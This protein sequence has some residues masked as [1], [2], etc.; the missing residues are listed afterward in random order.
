MA[1]KF[2]YPNLSAKLVHISCNFSN[3]SL[4]A[5][6]N[7]SSKFQTVQK[8]FASS[9]VLPPLLPPPCLHFCTP[10][11]ST[12]MGEPFENGG[13][14]SQLPNSRRSPLQNHF[15]P[16]SSRPVGRISPSLP[17]PPTPFVSLASPAPTSRSNS[18]P[19]AAYSFRASPSP[20]RR[21]RQI[22]VLRPVPLLVGT[23]H[24]QPSSRPPNRQQP[25]R[26]SPSA[27]RPS[28]TRGRAD[29]ISHHLARVEISQ[30]AVRAADWDSRIGTTSSRL[31][32]LPFGPPPP[33]IHHFLPLPLFSIS[34]TNLPPSPTGIPL[35]AAL[36]STLGRNWLIR[37]ADL[38]AELVEVWSDENVLQSDS[39]EQLYGYLTTESAAT[40]LMMPRTTVA[41]FWR[42]RGHVLRHPEFPCLAV[43]RGVRGRGRIGRQNAR[44][45]RPTWRE[46]SPHRDYIPIE[47]V[48]TTHMH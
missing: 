8:A 24:R 29:G 26:A 11:L 43:E 41:A 3:S 18:P 2:N 14:E 7:P 21:E 25:R 15:T 5:R 20:P 4:C 30:P 10:P 33:S 42:G 12:K 37:R 31:A 46:H 27:S 34:V 9:L 22:P 40:L 45:G 35:H 13:F 38:A 48:R 32:D 17:R 19:S 6:Q 1:L 28:G 16:S 39:G 23:R 44:A 36:R 47:L